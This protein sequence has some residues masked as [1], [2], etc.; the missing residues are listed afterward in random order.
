MSDYSKVNL[1]DVD[2]SS[3]NESIQARFGRKLL[4]SEE[5]GVS[6]FQ[7]APGFKATMSHSHKEQEEVYVVIKGTGHI[8]LDDKVEAIKPFDTIRVAAPVIRAFK[9]GPEGLEIIAIGGHKPADGDGVRHD[10]TWPN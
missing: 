1:L 5:L 8:L 10:A 9:A 3:D 6:L 4:D 2:S 7:Y